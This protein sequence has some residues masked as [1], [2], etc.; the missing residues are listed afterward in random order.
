[1]TFH[2]YMNPMLLLQNQ[3]IDNCVDLCVAELLGL[4]YPVG[5]LSL[6]YVVRQDPI[7]CCIA[8]LIALLELK[9]WHLSKPVQ[10]ANS[11]LVLCR[12]L[13][14]LVVVKIE[15]GSRSCRLGCFGWVWWVNIAKIQPVRTDY[16]D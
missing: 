14:T 6:W 4:A 7:N 8:E 11:F 5:A 2:K 1:M 16:R 10:L 9:F 12:N 3:L 13:I 15:G